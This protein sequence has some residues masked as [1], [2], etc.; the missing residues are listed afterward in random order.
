MPWWQELIIWVL[1]FVAYMTLL[2]W[3]PEGWAVG[4]VLLLLIL[5]GV[6]AWLVWK[7]R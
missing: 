6:A 4:K 7:R 1:A 3:L 2:D 5:V